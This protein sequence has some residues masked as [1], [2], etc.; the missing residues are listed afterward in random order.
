MKFKF[1]KSLAAFLCLALIS[2]CVSYIPITQ[3][4]ASKHNMSKAEALALLEQT[5]RNHPFP[6]AEMHL[7]ADFS[8]DRRLASI[9]ANGYSYMQATGR[10][11]PATTTSTPYMT[12]KTWKA[13]GMVGTPP[14]RFADVTQLKAMPSLSTGRKRP[15]ALSLLLLLGNN[16]KTLDQ[17]ELFTRDINADEVISA[18]LTLCPNVR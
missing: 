16:G 7:G 10:V 6:H 18:L 13:A 15:R 2:G 9:D 1:A 5:L 14:I 4:Y 8:S 17:I 12:T 3:S 11:G